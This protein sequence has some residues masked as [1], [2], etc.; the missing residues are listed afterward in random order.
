[1]NTSRNADDIIRMAQPTTVEQSQHLRTFSQLIHDNPALLSQVSSLVYSR[2]WSNERDGHTKAASVKEACHRLR[3]DNRVHIGES[4]IALIAR[5]V[6]YL[7]PDLDGVVEVCSS[8]LFDEM[9]GMRIAGK[10]LPGDYA[11]RLEWCDGRP[12][13]EAPAPAPQ[14]KTVQSVQPLPAQANLFGEVA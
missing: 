2:V 4:L 8:K 5:A 9:L 1:M 7:H 13:T 6:L 3:W 14:K 12:L 11:R 10:K